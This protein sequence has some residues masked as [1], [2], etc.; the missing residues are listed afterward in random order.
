MLQKCKKWLLAGA[1]LLVVLVAAIIIRY[2]MSEGKEA[3]DLEEVSVETE[4]YQG[5]VAW[6]E[7]KYEKVYD[8]NIDFPA[9]VS[10]VKVKEGDR[11]SLGQELVTLDMTEYLGLMD[12]LREQLRAGEAGLKVTQQ[13]TAALSADI[14]QIQKD[15][16]TKTEELSKGTNSDIEILQR[17]LALAKK[18]LENAQR[19]VRNNRELYEA[20]SVSQEVLNQ[21]I[22]ILDQREKALSDIESNIKK[23]KNALQTELD[24]LHILLKSKQ[25]QL[26]Q[27]ENSN[28]ANTEKQDSGVETA[29]IDLETMQNKSTKDYLKNNSI[30]SGVK[31]GIV[32]NIGVINGTILGV[33]NMPTRILQ[34]IDADTIVVSAE[35]DEEFIKNVSLGQTVDIVPATDSSLSI[36]GVVT[37]ISN[38]AVE[39]DGKRIVKVEVK[40]QD[41]EGELKPG[42]SADVY[43]SGR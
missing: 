2:N 7:V 40:P 19:D 6:G 17:S 4:W 37:H 42:Y 15:I 31:N 43:F 16:K 30:V 33:Q 26:D 22:S 10:D 21:Y 20:G 14:A 12:K 29:R 11:V 36:P 13:D 28:F 9:V 34:L 35:V 1:G 24:Q 5:I 18:E 41:P 3:G 39:K 25:A 23:T 8:I 32:Q 38:L 27:I